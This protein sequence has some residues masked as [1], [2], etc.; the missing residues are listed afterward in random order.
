MVVT[1]DNELPEKLRHNHPLFLSTADTSG[2]V[3]I[4][5]QLTG[6][7]NYS[8]WSRTMRIAILERNKL[9]LIDGKCRKDGFC[10]NLSDLWER[11]NAIVLSW[12]M[13]CVSKKLL[14]GIVYSTYECSVWR[15][16]KERFDKTDGSRI[17]QLHREI[18]TL[19]QG[20]STI[21][22][23]FTKLR[24]CWAEFD[25]IVPFRGC[26]FTESR[27][28]VEFMKQ[29]KLL[30]FLLGLNETYEQARSQILM[31]V[32]LPSVNQA[33]SMMIER[34]SQRVIA[35]SARNVNNLEIAALMTA[36]Q[37][38]NKFKGDW[39]A[40]CDH[41][42][43][44]GHTKANCFRLI[45]YP[46]NFRFKKKVGQQNDSYEKEGENRSHAHNIRDEESRSHN[47]GSQARAAHVNFCNDQGYNNYPR[48]DNL[49]AD[50]N[51]SHIPSQQ[52]LQM[53]QQYDKSSHLNQSN[54]G[55]HKADD[56]P[57]PSSSNM[58]RLSDSK[59]GANF[60]KAFASYACNDDK[61]WIIDTGASNHM[62]SHKEMLNFRKP[63]ADYNKQ[64]TKELQCSVHFFPNYCVFQDL[65]SGKVL[66]IGEE[67]NG[68]Y[69]MSHRERGVD[70]SP[71][72]MVASKNKLDILLWHR[73]LP[74]IALN[75]KSPFEVFHGVKGSLTHL[76]TIGCLCYAKCLPPGDKFEAKAVPN[77]SPSPTAFLDISPTE[78]SPPHDVL[79]RP[80]IVSNIEV[81]D[82]DISTL[83][84]GVNSMPLRHI[85]EPKSYKE[86]CSD[87]RW[88]SA[89][90][91][92]IQA[93]EANKTW[94]IVPLPSHKKPIGCKWV[95]KIKFK[96]DG[97]KKGILMN[98][99]KYALELIEE[100]GLTAAKPSWT[101]LDI[102][103]KLTNTLLD[104]AMNITDSNKAMNITNDQVLADKGP[105]QRLI[106]RLL[107]LTLSRPDIGF[108]VQTL[109]QFLQCPKKSHMEAALKVVRYIKREPTM[110]VLMS[111]KKD[112]ELIAFCDADWAAC[113]NTRRSVAGF[114]IKHGESL[115]SWKSKKQ[116]TVSRSSAESE[117]RSMASTVS[118]LV[119]IIALYKELG[120]EIHLPVKLFCDSE[121]AL[122]IEANPVY[123][124]RT[125]H[126][127]VGCHFIREKI[128][129]G[130]IQTLYIR[131]Q[132]QQADI[133]TKGLARAQHEHLV[134][135][136]GVLNVFVP[137][138]L[139]GSNEKG[140]ITL[141]TKISY[142][143]L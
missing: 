112:R 11:C 139:R 88:I 30:Q 79:D 73:R 137:T 43:M 19:V 128:Q 104:E 132:E 84:V 117:Y 37:V 18:V 87:P 25:C 74:S 7:E 143:K 122:Q 15:D 38:P 131:T 118:E 136:L 142:N 21:A 28:F 13:N 54:L 29:Q 27:G 26:N 115:I 5:I 70:C 44:M 20:T 140:V 78:D 3:L 102:N 129:I 62:I 32:P 59:M 119:W 134:S 2:V 61:E 82:V 24:L 91:E 130:L 92:K 46:S 98:Q 47:D 126:I 116:T 109:S 60:S 39:N 124:E 89:M 12:I 75:N 34:E 10:P 110:G 35:N 123:H 31:L 40:Q 56:V 33:Y 57:E 65:S 67:K 106:G 100:M 42:K 111:S 1:V 99:R 101:P 86:A 103:L 108:A 63:V 22:E 127:E 114:L 58:C 66:E 121:A 96:A 68:L 55:Q 16:L 107:Y 53:M 64:I 125:K 95:Y 6:A 94:L 93:L 23:Y 9:G 105:Y 14:G 45:G 69:M 49:H 36:R 8:V 77:T 141:L 41:C 138:S 90:K 120:E 76:R 80:D 71:K 81:D 133:M 51:R 4:S 135:K 50:W 85:T 17:F 113:P 48:N 52:H 97:T 72:G 83:P